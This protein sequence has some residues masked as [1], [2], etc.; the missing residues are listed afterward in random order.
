M[1]RKKAEPKP[2]S[3]RDDLFEH[4]ISCLP[5]NQKH[6]TVER[7]AKNDMIQLKRYEAFFRLYISDTGL[8]ASIRMNTVNCT[9]R[10]DDEPLFEPKPERIKE[11]EESSNTDKDRFVAEFC[12]MYDFGLAETF[13]A[14]N[15]IPYAWEWESHGEYWI[16]DAWLYDWIPA[17]MMSGSQYVF[18]RLKQEGLRFGNLAYYAR[19][20]SLDEDGALSKIAADIEEAAKL[21]D[22]RCHTD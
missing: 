16:R 20:N 5:E 2:P 3:F 9:W 21:F 7:Y 11:Y 18:E 14:L 12:E 8:R 4:C 19:E 10:I 22:E 17:F 6:I 1:P 15:E 13:T